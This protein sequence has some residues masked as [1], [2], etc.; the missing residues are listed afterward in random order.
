MGITTDNASNN[1]TFI[2]S[3]SEWMNEENI[4]FNNNNHFRCFAHVINLSV[5][6][7]L[8]SL[9]NN[10]DQVILKILFLNYFCKIII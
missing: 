9:K 3:L 4:F 2:E 7:A 5:Q 10:L 6:V 8:N 1:N